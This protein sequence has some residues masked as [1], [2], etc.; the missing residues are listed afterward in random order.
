MTLHFPL[1]TEFLPLPFLLMAAGRWESLF[2]W[3]AEMWGTQLLQQGP[4]TQQVFHLDLLDDVRLLGLQFLR[5]TL[6]Q[7]ALVGIC[8]NHSQWWDHLLS[9]MWPPGW[10]GVAWSSRSSLQGR[11]PSLVT[12]PS[13]KLLTGLRSHRGETFYQSG[14]FTCLAA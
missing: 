1:A 6:V 3:C 9:T 2:S 11:E 5:Q 7:L 12:C 13:L 14:K 10:R 4:S 8:W